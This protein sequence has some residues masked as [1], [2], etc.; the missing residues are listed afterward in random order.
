MSNGSL[1]VAQANA[2]TDQQVGALRREAFRGIAQ[3]AA[4]VP[5]APGGVGET[6]VNVGVAN[7]GGETAGGI[8]VAHQLGASLNLN[9]GVGFAGGGKLRSRAG[10]QQG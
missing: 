4:L 9:A 10:C 8:A 2:Y 5:L 3:A 7:Y 1:G 6:T